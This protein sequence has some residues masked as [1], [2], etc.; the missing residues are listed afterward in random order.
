[1]PQFLPMQTE[2][3]KV[4]D[5]I[6]PS[7][8]T[9]DVFNQIYKMAIDGQYHNITVHG[10]GFCQTCGELRKRCECYEFNENY[11]PCNCKFN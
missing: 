9:P 1:M 4:L 10:H 5:E 6:S 8:S 3:S 11:Q 7:V 2:L